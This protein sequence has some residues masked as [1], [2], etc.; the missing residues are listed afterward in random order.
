MRMYSTSTL[1]CQGHLIRSRCEPLAH[2]VTSV[3]GLPACCLLAVTAAPS[4]PRMQP[5][6]FY[7]LSVVGYQVFPL[8]PA[9][10]E[11][12]LPQDDYR[13]VHC[14]GATVDGADGAGG[15]AQ[16]VAVPP[17]VAS[18]RHAGRAPR[19]G[20]TGQPRPARHHRPQGANASAEGY[21]C[22]FVCWRC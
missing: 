2:L 8:W 11:G 21:M 5:D 14:R 6:V 12:M 18:R 19:V 17:R 16:I 1:P 22:C 9:P 4:Q 3:E 15:A 7:Q 20:A 10:S 13:N